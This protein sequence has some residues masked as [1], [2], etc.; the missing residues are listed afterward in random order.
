L[1]IALLSDIHSNLE[2]LDACVSHAIENA[3][4]R[5]VFLGDLVG[6]GADPQ[7]VVAT[8]ARRTA[9]G[10]IAVK[11]NHDEAI[12][13]RA[14]YMNDAAKDSIDWTRKTLSPDCISFLSQLP[15]IVREGAMCFVHASAAAPARWDYVDSPGAARRSA[16]AARATYTFSGHV[17]EQSLYFE[18]SRGNW[19]V[20]QPTPGSPVPM[21]RHRRWLALVG[22]VGQPRDGKPAAAY[23]LFDPLSEQITFQRVAYDH[24]AAAQKIRRAGLPELHA[25]RVEKGI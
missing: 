4:E 20:F 11:G 5:F 19:S 18:G 22:S 13:R 21:G 9:E 15:L 16:E 7:E 25:Y 14:S 12:E 23:A 24:L 17:H 10:A 8:V 6:Y 3:A 1:V 2:A